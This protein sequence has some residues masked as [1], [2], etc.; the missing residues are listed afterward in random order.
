MAPLIPN[1][2]IHPELNLFFAFIIGLGFGYVL[3]Q[4]GFSSSRKLAG[5][6]YGYDFVVLR[7]FF[8]AGITALTGLLILAQLGWVEWS[9]LYVNPTYL[10]SAIVGG[11]IMGFGFILGGFCPGTS[12]V[13][14]VIGRI[15]AIVFVV[16]MMAG[17]FI[18]GEFFPVFKPLYLG[19]YLGGLYVYDVFGISRDWFALMLVLMALMAFGVTR[20]IEDKVNKVKENQIH[21]RP[22][23]FIPVIV[24]LIL[25]FI[26]IMLPD[27]KASRFTE[28]STDLMLDE[29]QSKNRLVTAD[30]VAYSLMGN[31]TNIVLVDIRP[32]EKHEAFHLPGSISVPLGELL[33]P[34]WKDIFKDHKKRIVFYSNSQSLA[35]QAWFIARRAGNRNAFVLE[36]GLNNLFE[37]VFVEKPLPDNSDELTQ[38]RYRF[39]NEA[40]SFFIQGGAIKEETKPQVPI[41]KIIEIKAPTGGG[42]C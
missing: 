32:V 38:Q 8:T 6:F 16:G 12:M 22:S 11:A 17:V 23:Y 3:E 31:S 7:V 41:K 37:T 13:G 19:D 35:D 10:W 36:G 25:A 40:R 20:I 28:T 2:F 18:F 1:G 39:L 42:G 26:N 30:E 33:A 24:L 14:A 29:M 27:E 21:G 34:E 15:D 9:M 5:V 4:A